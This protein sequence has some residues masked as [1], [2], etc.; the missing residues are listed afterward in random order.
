[1]DS[2][3]PIKKLR[4][5]I[6]GVEGEEGERN[7]AVLAR[8]WA[9]SLAPDNV[10]DSPEERSPTAGSCCQGTWMLRHRLALVQKPKG[11]I[12]GTMGFAG[13]DGFL[14]LPPEEALYLA[15]KGL[16][17]IDVSDASVDDQRR[18]LVAG[19]RK[20]LDTPGEL[21]ASLTGGRSGLPL[22]CYLVYR[23]L[24]EMQYVVRR[25]ARH[26]S[27]SG[28]G[29]VRLDA[30][31]LDVPLY[32]PDDGDLGEG[33]VAFEAF[34]W[35][36]AFSKSRPGPPAFAVLVVNAAE[37]GPSLAD[38]RRLAVRT[39]QAYEG[40]ETHLKVATVD[41]EGV[42]NLLTLGTALSARPIYKPNRP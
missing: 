10:D 19:P 21:Y 16:L 13:V 11:K 26:L 22:A 30:P 34:P 8:R 3:A 33:A 35:T 2:A 14:S 4:K 17:A 24:R 31:L 37:A 40:G 32:S 42:V 25:C 18:G 38:L 39:Q 1:M 27:A 6:R 5:E 23:H 20:S 9:E 36:A 28:N 29:R 15:E 12:I 41:G 7:F